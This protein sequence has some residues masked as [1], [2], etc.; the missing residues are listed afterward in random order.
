MAKA[1]A[2]AWCGAAALDLRERQER[3]LQERQSLGHSRPC[4]VR[5]LG[6]VLMVTGNF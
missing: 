5:S 2:K 1:K 3:M 6:F 4:P